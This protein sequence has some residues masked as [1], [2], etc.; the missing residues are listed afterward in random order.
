MYNRIINAKIPNE[1]AT[2]SVKIQDR[3]VY[4]RIGTLRHAHTRRSIQE[5]VLGSTVFTKRKS[6][7]RTNCYNIPLQQIMNI[8]YSTS[9][10]I[11][12]LNQNVFYNIWLRSRKINKSYD[13]LCQI[14]C[15]T[16]QCHGPAEIKKTF[17]LQ[18]YLQLLISAMWRTVIC[19]YLRTLR[20]YLLPP[21]SEQSPQP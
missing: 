17:L 2:A 21:S 6:C 4:Q 18:A 5:H 14:I 12:D 16:V 8:T 19:E 13:D 11:I 9:N 7:T 3:R 1:N 10:L 15:Y 20:R